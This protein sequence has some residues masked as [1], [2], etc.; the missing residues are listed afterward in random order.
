[1]LHQF[2]QDLKQKRERAKRGERRS[3]IVDRL[4]S[5]ASDG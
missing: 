3:S 4:A 2:D 1:M 5:N